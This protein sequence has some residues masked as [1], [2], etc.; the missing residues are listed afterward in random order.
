MLQTGCSV[1]VCSARGARTAHRLLRRFGDPPR[2]V[3]VVLEQVP[4]HS[5]RRLDADAGEAAAPSTS[6]SSAGFRRQPERQLV[7]GGSP[8]CR[9]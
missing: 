6:P 3:A 1:K 2:A 5:L 9:R 4:G 7:P 8:A